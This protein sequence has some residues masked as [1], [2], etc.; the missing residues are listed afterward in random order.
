MRLALL[1]LAGSLAAGQAALAQQR[2]CLGFGDLTAEL[3]IGTVTA[4]P[5]AY[6]LRGDRASPDCP[7]ETP[8]CQER[9]YLVPSDQVILGGASAPG[10][11]CALYVNPRGL[12]RA[13]WLPEAAVAR[14]PP[15]PAGV[16][17]D[18]LGEW[19]GGPEHRISIRRG[20]RPG[21]L[22]IEGEATYGAQDPDRV[23]RGAVNMGEIAAEVGPKGPLLGF[24]MGMGGTQPY[25]AG[26]PTDC[27]ARLRLLG[28]WL[29]AEDNG[30]C[31]GMNVSF[32]GAY[33]RAPPNPGGKSR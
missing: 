12:A 15:G 3:A 28:P 31:G 24:T 4:G 27:R 19:R 8:A 20:P 7:A 29:L 25:E 32:S 13:G 5:R 2:D 23:R 9:A 16:P 33:R 11:A 26:E 30:A 18:W 6:F 10:F 17:E 22:R 14:Q 21:T 1:A